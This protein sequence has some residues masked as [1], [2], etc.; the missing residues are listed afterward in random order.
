MLQDDPASEA[1]FGSRLKNLVLRTLGVT[2]GFD[3]LPSA[4]DPSCVMYPALNLSDLD[5]KRD[6]FAPHESG[7][8]NKVFQS[9]GQ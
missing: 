8:L 7:L 2:V 1:V 5:K 3:L 4:K 6:Q 9:T